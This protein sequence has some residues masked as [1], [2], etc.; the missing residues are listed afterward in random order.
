MPA[1]ECRE[2]GG[3]M[4]VS[5]IVPNPCPESS[6]FIEKRQEETQRNVQGG[7]AHDK[8]RRKQGDRQY[9]QV[10]VSRWRHNQKCLV[11][12]STVGIQKSSTVARNGV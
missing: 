8:E 6:Q 10:S 7:G 4:G 9:A 12:E 2:D 3:D 11:E 5:G 1:P